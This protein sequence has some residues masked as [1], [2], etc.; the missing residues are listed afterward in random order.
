[1]ANRVRMPDRSIFLNYRAVLLFL[2]LSFSTVLLYQPNFKV[3][4][5]NSDE[6]GRINVIERRLD[7]DDKRIDDLEQNGSPSSRMNTVEVRDINTKIASLEESVW[8][9][10]GIVYGFGSLISFIE[11]LQALGF[12]RY[13]I[14]PF[15]KVDYEEVL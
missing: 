2:I 8:I 13:R 6:S 12:M 11:L 3:H 5:Q 1:M 15:K 7:Y 10:K 14:S 9:W 4:A